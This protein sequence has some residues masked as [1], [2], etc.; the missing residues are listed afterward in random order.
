MFKFFRNRQEGPIQDFQPDAIWLESRPVPLP[1]HTVWLVVFA[2]LIIGVA[3]TFWAKVDKIVTAQGKLV[4]TRPNITMKPLERTVIEKVH[5]QAGDRVKAGQILFTFDRTINLA[6]LERLREQRSSLL[7]QRARLLAEQENRPFTPPAGEEDSVDYRLQK[8]IHQARTLN[9]QE[10]I[11]TYDE[12]INRYENTISAMLESIRKYNDRQLKVDQIE[13]IF[14]D[15]ERVG[16]TS[17]KDL[18]S[19]QIQV[20]GMALQVDE[21]RIQITEYQHQL[22]ALRAEKNTFLADWRRQIGEELVEV[23]RQLIEVEKAIP[24]S[25][26]LDKQFEL[27]APCDAVVHEIAP[28]QEGSAVREAESLITLVPVNVPLEAEVDIQA[29]DI[30]IVKLGDQCRLKFDAFPFQQ[31]GTLDGKV[32]NLSQDAFTRSAEESRSGEGLPGSYY[33]ARIVYSGDFTGSA[34]GAPLTPGMRLTAE[35]KVGERSVIQYLIN[36]LIKALDEAIREP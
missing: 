10:K 23:E 1:A 34:K 2:L 36:P 14:A 17:T 3:W 7:A 19:T 11:N 27:R 13:K 24:K 26:M 9:Y 16:A 15:L 20:I 12:N 35:I 29:K 31:N 6:E 28:F 22:A 18:L 25:E 8:L 33:R 5:V 4:T 32:V 30:G 21:Q